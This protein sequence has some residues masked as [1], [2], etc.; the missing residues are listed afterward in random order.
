MAF[1]LQLFQSNPKLAYRVEEIAQQIG[2]KKEEME[3]DLGDLIE[4]GVVKGAANPGIFSL[5]VQR[6]R[7]IEESVCKRLENRRE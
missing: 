3:R 5:N 7:E 4:I 2:R 1:P 6:L